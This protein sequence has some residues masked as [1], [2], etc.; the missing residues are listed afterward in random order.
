MTCY[1]SPAKRAGQIHCSTFIIAILAL[2]AILLSTNSP[3]WAETS[4]FTSAGVPPT[5]H[6]WTPQDFKQFY[7]V[8]AKEK[9][10]LPLLST[11][12][13]KSLLTH[14]LDEENTKSLLNSQLALGVRMQNY[15][16]LQDSMNGLLKL[17]LAAHNEGRIKASSEMSRVM[18]YLLH[19]GSIG[20]SLTSEFL[21]TIPRDEHYEIRMEG[22][23]KMRLGLAKIFV[24]LEQTLGERAV[25]SPEDLSLLLSAMK[26]ELPTYRPMF[27]QAFADELSK[28]LQSRTKEFTR[29]EDRVLLSE[30]VTLLHAQPQSIGRDHKA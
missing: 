19:L 13:G 12:D 4:R 10:S 7:E 5:D 17:Y 15:L 9:T 24:G 16:S 14:V 21:P 25:Y 8:F 22:L 1:Q 2:A 30:M 26:R 3:V 18:A 23:K 20:I 6:V 27:D 28:K 29:S 11:A